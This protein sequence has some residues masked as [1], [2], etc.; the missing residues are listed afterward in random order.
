MGSIVGL[1]QFGDAVV[2]IYLRRSQRT[3]SQELLYLPHIGSSV[4]QMGGE[5]VAQYVRTAFPLYAGH[6]QFGVYESIDCTAADTLPLF[7]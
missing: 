1:F 2:G 4:E 3:V 5:R 6:A 7:G